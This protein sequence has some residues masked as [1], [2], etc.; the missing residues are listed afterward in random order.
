[1]TR[2]EKYP[3]TVFFDSAEDARLYRRYLKHMKDKTGINNGYTALKSIQYYNQTI[4]EKG[5]KV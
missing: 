3:V 5:N 4:D 2:G 1:M